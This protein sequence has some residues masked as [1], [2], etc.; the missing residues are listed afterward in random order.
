MWVAFWGDV[1]RYTFSPPSSSVGEEASSSSETR[2]GTGT[3]GVASLGDL[4]V[5]DL[6]GLLWQRWRRKIG[7]N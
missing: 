6:G 1:L 3:V 2:Q 4:V 7:A 5:E